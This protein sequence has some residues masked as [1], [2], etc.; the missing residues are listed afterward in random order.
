MDDGDKLANEVSNE[1]AAL[2]FEDGFLK[3]TEKDETYDGWRLTALFGKILSREIILKNRRMQRQ[4]SLWFD[5]QVPESANANK[6]YLY[7]I[8]C[9]GQ[10][11]LRLLK[12]GK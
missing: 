12:D 6:G 7:G 1:Y 8:N 5:I 11:S 4:R 10:Y 3:L 2:N 9:V